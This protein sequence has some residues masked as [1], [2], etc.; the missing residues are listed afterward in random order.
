M[1]RFFLLLIIQIMLT[2]LAAQAGTLQGKI[3]DEQGE[4]LPFANIF[5]QN[6]TNGTNANE[7]GFY[8]FKLPAGTYEIVFK[9]IGFKPQV[10]TLTIGQGTLDFD[11]KLKPEAYSLQEVVVKASA[12]DPAYA[13]VK[14][15]INRRKFHLKET[16]A[17]KC[18]VYIKNLMR[19]TDV[20]NT[21]V[22]LGKVHELKRVVA[23]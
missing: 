2:G 11:V 21:G 1:F 8:Q 17:Y 10:H 3:T 15:A 18:R 5:V 12:K 6:S 23:A 22:G 4:P 19:V 9:Y 16:E 14:A 20:P 7:L 13:M